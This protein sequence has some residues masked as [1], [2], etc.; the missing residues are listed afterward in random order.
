MKEKKDD[1]REEA[2]LLM[3]ELSLALT[4]VFLRADVR[5]G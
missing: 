5:R 4:D 3:A 2:S 1:G